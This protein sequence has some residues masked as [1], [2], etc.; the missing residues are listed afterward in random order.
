[1][2]NLDVLKELSDAFGPSGFEDDVV[3]VIKKHCKDMIVENDAM[4]N[5]F[6]R[7]K[8]NVNKKITVMLDAHT[9]EVGFMVQAI[10]DNGLLSIVKLG[11]WHNTTIPAHTVYIKNRD[12]ELIRGITTSKPSHFMSAAEKASSSLEIEDI[13]IDVGVSSREEVIDIFKIKVGDPVAPNVEFDFNEKTGICFGKAFDN[14]V[15]C[16]CIIETLRALAKVTDL[17]VNVVGAFAAQE[18]V[19]IRGAQIT[20]NVVNPDL[21][22]VFEGSPAD[23]LYYSKNISQGT[24]KN[25]AQ[26]RNLDQ[27]YIGNPLFIRFAEELADN[28]SIRY[29]NAVRRGGSTDAAKISLGNKA[30]PCLVLG[31]PSRYVHSHYNY[32]AKDDI[33][34]AVELA[35]EVIKNLTE[36]TNSFIMKKGK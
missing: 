19:G 34:A 30:V 14:R 12:G 31:I 24:L 28:N 1:M 11:G 25:G 10:N 22:I 15:G 26:I 23:D 6:A 13:F 29:Q 8:N 5:V 20:T 2:V 16:F 27:G 4:N 33:E 17:E 21:A 36:E 3:E 32:C 9:D 7:L 18:E 35:V